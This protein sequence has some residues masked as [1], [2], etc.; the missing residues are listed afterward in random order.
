[1]EKMQSVF[2]ILLVLL[3]ASVQSFH[4]SAVG[5]RPMITPKVLGSAFAK[6]RQVLSSTPLQHEA[7][8]EIPALSEKPVLEI[9]SVEQFTKLVEGMKGA[10]M[11]DF[12]ADWCGP[13]KVSESVACVPFV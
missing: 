2:L 3:F 9:E 5:R 10:A 12:F 13:C 11:V 1:M 7:F 6:N 8:T 4:F